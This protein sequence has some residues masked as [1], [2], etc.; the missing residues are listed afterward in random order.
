M[1]DEKIKTR[2]HSGKP[3]GAI[4]VEA[5]NSPAF[6]ALRES[7][8]IVEAGEREQSVVQEEIPPGYEDIVRGYFDR[9]Q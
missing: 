3:L 7:V 9:G 8:A 2:W 5:Q 4:E 1:T 6:S